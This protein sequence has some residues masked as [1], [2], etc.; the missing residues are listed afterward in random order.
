MT[1][2]SI[3]GIFNCFQLL[4]YLPAESHVIAQSILWWS[5]QDLKLDKILIEIIAEES[6]LNLR[7]LDKKNG[8]LRF[9][10][11]KEK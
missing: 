8:I 1:S 9:S 4:R 5:E 6:R 11:L 3:P 7:E 2:Q 10:L